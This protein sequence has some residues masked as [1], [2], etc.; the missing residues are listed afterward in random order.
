[1]KKFFVLISFLLICLCCAFFGGGA[2]YASANSVVFDLSSS[3]YSSQGISQNTY[4]VF[5]AMAIEVLGEETTSFK[6][7]FFSANSEEMIAS[8]PVSDDGLAIK[9][10]VL[11]GLLD[12][13]VGQNARYDC[14]KNKSTITSLSGLN[15]MTFDGIDT[16]ILNDNRIAKVNSADLNGFADLENIFIE[17]NGLTDFAL[18]NY[19]N[20]KIENL[21]LC[22]N[23]LSGFSSACLKDDAELSLRGNAIT[24]LADISVGQI[25]LSALDLRFN[26]IANF[27]RTA[28]QNKFGVVPVVLVQNLK[29]TYNAGEKI[30]VYNDE[31]YNLV[32]HASY[33]SDSSYWAGEE[34]ITSTTGA[35]DFEALT[36]PAGKIVISFT[37]DSLPGGMDASIFDSFLLSVVPQKP[38]YTIKADGKQS[39]A[40]VQSGDFEVS[41]DFGNNQNLPNAEDF[42][43]HAVLK[44]TL[45]GSNV[46]LSNN[47][48]SISQNGTY[49]FNAYVTFDGLESEK[50]AVT[51]TRNNN[52]GI[53]L[54]IILALLV[55]VAASAVVVLR[56]WFGEGGNVAPLS[57]AEVKK[58]SR[59]SAKSDMGESVSPIKK[60]E[61]RSAPPVASEDWVD[62]MPKDK[63]KDEKV[64]IPKPNNNSGDFPED[65]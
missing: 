20:G 29:G 13:T 19:F 40:L 51:V 44:T 26:K 41:F 4:K 47:K 38:S 14:L 31:A 27:D 30:Y 3:T 1:M 43:S 25:S 59:Y 24:D 39:T 16:L 28:A 56:R 57:D 53:V 55:I 52:S 45:N 37:Y 35:Q 11:S 34:Y 7:N 15:K 54:G 42:A 61:K 58:Y 22:G 36:I 50:L 9:S 49:S 12:L 65:L 63:P 64:K 2:I 17:N 8:S 5:E 33:S 48:V 46:A 23:N 62:L 21:S 32:A 10:D 60:R 6:S 18:S